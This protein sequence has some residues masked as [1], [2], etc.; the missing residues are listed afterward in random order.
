M[1]QVVL[2]YEKALEPQQR[3]IQVS[4]ALT[5]HLHRFD[6]DGPKLQYELTERGIISLSS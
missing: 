1:H 6:A 2:G 3:S 4:K 5:A